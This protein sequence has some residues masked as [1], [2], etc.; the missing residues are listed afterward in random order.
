M[1][2]LGVPYDDGYEEQCVTDLEKQAEEIV[3]QLV[4]QDADISQQPPDHDLDII[5]LIAYL[6]RLGTD[7]KVEGEI[8]MNETGN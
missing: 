1:R 6:Q 8:S 2:T 5:A 3:K 4:E 7:I